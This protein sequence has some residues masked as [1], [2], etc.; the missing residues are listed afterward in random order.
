M[1]K[2]VKLVAMAVM[3]QGGA[4]WTVLSFDTIRYNYGGYVLVP[5]G[6]GW[7]GII[8][9]ENGMYQMT[10]HLAS[11]IGGTPTNIQL[12]PSRNAAGVPAAGLSPDGGFL[13]DIEFQGAGNYL[14]ATFTTMY[15]LKAGD[16]M[17]MQVL[18]GGAAMN[19]VGGWPTLELL[20]L[21]GQY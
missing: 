2:A 14:A 21:G 19:T 6:L 10:G 7:R 13:G 12:M 5:G 4:V 20:K 3:A 11:T 17:G 15:E 16:E 1:P 8:V 9:P 18:S